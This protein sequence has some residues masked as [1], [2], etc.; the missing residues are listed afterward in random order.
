MKFTRVRAGW[1]ESV[2]NHGWVIKQISGV[3]MVLWA[4]PGSSFGVPQCYA[5]TLAEAKAKVRVLD[6]AEVAA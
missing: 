5:P 4:K 2:G 3:W 6:N 1:Y